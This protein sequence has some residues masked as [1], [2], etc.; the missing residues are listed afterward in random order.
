METCPCILK[1]HS[2][3]HL[4]THTLCL[5]ILIQLLIPTSCTWG[6]HVSMGGYLRRSY[7]YSV[8]ACECSIYVAAFLLVWNIVVV[9][10]LVSAYMY[11][12]LQTHMAIQGHW[13]CNRIY[14]QLHTSTHAHSLY[15]VSTVTGSYCACSMLTCFPAPHSW[16]ELYG[17]YY[18]VKYR[19]NSD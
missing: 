18:S 9:S 2:N 1:W 6:I 7:G 11:A 3:A 10:I 19:I 5:N 14:Y 16:I 17:I 8:C 12:E 13:Q 15:Q 4:L